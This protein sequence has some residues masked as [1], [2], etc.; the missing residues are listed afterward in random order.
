LS[1]GSA[2]FLGVVMALRQVLLNSPWSVAAAG[3]ARIIAG[4]STM[5]VP[6]I[7]MRYGVLAMITN[8]E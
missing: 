4:L 3:Q 5:L 2:L 6:R 7:R 1:G 8:F